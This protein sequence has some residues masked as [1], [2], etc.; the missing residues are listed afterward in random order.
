VHLKSIT[1]RGF[2]SF[3][4]RTRLEFAP[5]VS[6]VVGPNG[7][8]KSNVTD[9]VL[10]A[11][12]EQSPVAVRGQSMQ[13]VIFGGAPGRQ[14]AKAAEVELVLDNSDGTLEFGLPE[15]S[16]FR[17]LDRTGEGEYRIAGA[18]CRL[19]D[20]IELLSDTGLG[21]EM[22]SVISQGRVES[23]VTSKPRDRRLL[24]EEA[25]GLGKH[26]KRRRRA[27]LKL[28]RTVDNL[29]RALDVE[30]EARSRLRPLKRQAEA[31][32]LHARLER[33]SL[34]ARW[35]LARDDTRAQR[36]ERA[37]AEA[38]AAGARSRLS[39]LEGELASVAKRR[40][41]AETALAQRS[42]QR[43]EL[44]RRCFAARGSG[45][46]VG[47]RAEA[48]RAAVL[49]TEARLTSSRHALEALRAQAQA[50]APD[51]EAA[52]RVTALEASLAALEDDRRAEL[53]RDLA[54][55]DGRRARAA[56]ELEQSAQALAATVTAREAVDAAADAVRRELRD[57]ERAVEAARR[58]A[59]R[60]GGQLAAVNQFLRA[61]AGAAGGA[62]ALAATL[63][64]E[65]G[66]E[67]A[68]AAALDGRMGA[69]VVPDR[70]AGASLLDRAGGDGGRALVAQ[71]G[72]GGRALVAQAGDSGAGAARGPSAPPV[73]DAQRL[74]DLLS[75]ADEAV[76]LARVLLVD[77]WVVGTDDLEAVPD[78]FA[79]VAVTRAGRVWSGST[80]ELRQAPSVGEDRVL[81]ERNR[82]AELV[83]ASEAAVQAEV[84]AGAALDRAAAV[85]A[86]AEADSERAL[87]AQRAAGVIRDEAAEEERRIERRIERRRAAGDEGPGAD[88]RTQL[89]SELASERRMAERAERELV[90]RGRRIERLERAVSRD[91]ALGPIAVRL[92]DALDQASAAITARV[93]EFEAALA[94]DRQ[95][96]EHV[97]AELRACAQAEA[98]L[99]TRLH[100]A[101]EAVTAAAVRA[102][103]AR[104]RAAEAEASLRGIASALELEPEPA[105]DPLP[106]RE[107][108]VLAERVQRLARRREQ[109][110]P[111]NPLAQ[112][113][114]AEA[115]EHVEEL[116]HQRE[117]LDTALRELE[118]LIAET[119]RQIRETFEETFEAAARNFE[120]LAAQLFPG[121]R[122]RLRLVTE[123]DGPRPVLG[124]QPLP[125]AEEDSPD[126]EAGEA[127]EP[128]EEPR[129]DLDGVEIEVT[130]AGK[131]MKRLTLLSGGEK[132]M[133]A[134]AFLFAVFLARP[135][136]FY[137]LDEVEAALDDL[138]I[139]R[140]LALLARYS[141]RAQFIVV[142]HQKRTMEA[143]DSLYGVS[144]GSDGISKV[145]SRKLPRAAEAADA[146]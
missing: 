119:D 82:R 51:P 44:S 31:A 117:D 83:R 111:V 106:D 46:R 120:D 116:E 3:P 84:A 40:E 104:D 118:K 128:G 12:G 121:G 101:N 81:S 42:A 110:G 132:S 75:G 56:A 20:V 86:G 16:I 28:A 140:F 90:E 122:G 55:L 96:G 144:M 50:D 105:S 108:E 33:Q 19:V 124:G 61:H 15:V 134:L 8:G 60:I 98:E 14:A 107:R 21:K 91:E 113:E 71:D 112:E 129:E 64:V 38:A 43:E 78:T 89:L 68:L 126:G 63:Q 92:A 79:G 45:E 30:R 70:A 103:Q 109:L 57:A 65:P 72:D 17:R 34:E 53:E 133:T 136:P 114:Y 24:I 67:L 97:T 25:A 27:Q 93:A 2:K 5:G 135:C 94:D 123:R 125:A 77:T 35:E 4:D 127:E 95:A 47:Y 6:V 9:A 143:A 146:A 54:E 29:D 66:Y 145:I 36:E 69:A 85:L 18:R 58:E 74:A 115:L 99:Q 23:I 102:Q 39:G 130:P 49:A 88:R 41:A 52:T 141:S 32:E 59:A 62:A 87:A 139:D 100:A 7:S 142:T 80:R 131:D 13:D 1:L 26:R 76:A 37:Q 48:V 10:W 137:I 73:P 11:M 138:N 22:H